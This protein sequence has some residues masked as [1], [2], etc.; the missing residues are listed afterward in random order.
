MGIT[1]IQSSKCPPDSSFTHDPDSPSSIPPTL[2][3][4]CLDQ[5]HPISAMLTKLSPNHFSPIGDPPHCSNSNNSD[6]SSGN[7][8]DNRHNLLSP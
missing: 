3:H 7:N 6:S 8:N 5:C 2:P 4:P 1:F